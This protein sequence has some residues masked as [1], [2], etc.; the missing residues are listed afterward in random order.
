MPAP[1]AV[2]IQKIF[3]HDYSDNPYDPSIIG[4]LDKDTTILDKER[5]YYTNE[6]GDPNAIKFEIEPI[7]CNFSSFLNLVI[8]IL[9][10]DTIFG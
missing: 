8:K 10:L 4:I 6:Y 1:T 5:Q 2:R 3:P 9:L 7:K